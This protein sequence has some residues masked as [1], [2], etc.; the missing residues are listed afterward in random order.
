MKK[1]ALVSTSKKSKLLINREIV[2]SLTLVQLERAVGGSAT[3]SGDI[4]CDT[5]ISTKSL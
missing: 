5:S 3:C 4:T 2:A 1:T